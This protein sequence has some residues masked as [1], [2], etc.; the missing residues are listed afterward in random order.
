MNVDIEGMG[1]VMN[2]CAGTPG[3]E[4]LGHDTRPD[5]QVYGT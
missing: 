2:W 5:T 3:G 1:K 4:V